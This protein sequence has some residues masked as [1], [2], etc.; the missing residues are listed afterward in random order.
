[1]ARSA[2]DIEA[3]KPMESIKA[4]EFHLNETRVLIED[5]N[6]QILL[7]MEIRE[8]S[9]RLRELKKSK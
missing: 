8:T 6:S 9:R 4:D 7:A 2:I 3:K 1:M 5:L